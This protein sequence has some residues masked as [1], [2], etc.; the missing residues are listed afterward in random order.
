VQSKFLC[1]RIDH[2]LLNSLAG[3][4]RSQA[5]KAPE[6]SCRF[7]YPR[8]E[9]SSQSSQSTSWS[10]GLLSEQ[11]C[12]PTLLL[13]M[14]CIAGRP[15]CLLWLKGSPL[16]CRCWI[17]YWKVHH[18][19]ENKEKER[20]MKTHA[21]GSTWSLGVRTSTATWP[22][23][24]FTCSVCISLYNYNW[25]WGLSCKILVL[26][27]TIW[28]QRQWRLPDSFTSWTTV[29]GQNIQTLQ[30]ALCWTP[31]PQNLNVSARALPKVM[32]GVWF[33]FRPLGLVH[34]RLHWHWTLGAMGL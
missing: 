34:F 29:D 23:G 6:I 7:G 28:R 18:L 17:C 10:Q 20:G 11:V 31:A 15:R 1:L 12:D 33:H 22:S 24:S 4:E 30:H 32:L 21:K 8:L 16:V 13:T 26:R 14:D 2:S 19:F 5:R 25:R 9:G 3:S 27:W